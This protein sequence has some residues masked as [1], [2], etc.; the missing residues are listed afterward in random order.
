M[1]R[2]MMGVG[3]LHW[4][5]TCSGGGGGGGGGGSACRGT[6]RPLLSLERPST[7]PQ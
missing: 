4:L 2:S 1:G 7:L 3:Q 6:S 5:Y